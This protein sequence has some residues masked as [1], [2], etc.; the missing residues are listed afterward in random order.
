MTVKPN[1]EWNGFRLARFSKYK[2]WFEVQGVQVAA[3]GLGAAYS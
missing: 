3:H 1:E 2:L